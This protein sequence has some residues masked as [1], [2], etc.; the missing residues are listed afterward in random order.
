MLTD[1]CVHLTDCL[2]IA[3]IVCW[4]GP[5]VGMACQI[6]LEKQLCLDIFKRYS[7]LFQRQLLTCAATQQRARDSV[8]V[9]SQLILGL[10]LWLWCSNWYFGPLKHRLAYIVSALRYWPPTFNAEM[11]YT[12]SCDGCSRC[13][14]PPPKPQWRWWHI[15]L[16]P[17]VEGYLCCSHWNEYGND[18]I[19]YKKNIQKY[20]GSEL[21]ENLIVST[22]QA[23]IYTTVYLYLI[24]I[25]NSVLCMPRVASMMGE[26]LVW[27]PT[28]NIWQIN[29]LSLYLWLAVF[30]KIPVSFLTHT[31]SLSLHGSELPSN[32]CLC[33]LK[34]VY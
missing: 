29:F 26:S 2:H 27:Q 8:T 22:Q 28:S 25:D 13:Y 31:S 5:A 11:T 1:G 9:S 21:L 4:S 18:N 34:W 14:V 6:M 23:A 10:S 12:L 16:P 3:D 32:T 7:E 30:G 15:F 24:S 33:G 20:T 17:R 19:Y